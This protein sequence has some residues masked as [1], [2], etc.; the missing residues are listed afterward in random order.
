MVSVIV[1]PSTSTLRTRPWMS[2]QALMF[3]TSP[4]GRSLRV[5]FRS[6]VPL[7][8]RRTPEM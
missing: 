7:P 8:V 3:F 1:M 5:A 2:T 6:M 4:L